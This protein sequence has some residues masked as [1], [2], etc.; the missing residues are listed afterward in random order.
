MTTWAE[1]LDDVVSR[2][3]VERY[4]FLCSDDNPD[5]A[6]R[7][8]YRRLVVDL[9][10]GGP[11]Y[12]SLAEQAGSLAAAAAGFVASGFKLVGEGEQARRLEICRGCE[13]FDA[14]RG[15]CKKCGCWTL[16]KTR[17][18]SQKCPIGKWGAR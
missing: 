8:G 1:A 13:F 4:R 17:L 18:A 14:P 11:Q 16:A 5:A 10:G 6:T 7:E 2:T 3:G 9:A 15:K 12:P